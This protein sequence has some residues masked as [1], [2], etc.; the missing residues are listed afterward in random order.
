MK[1]QDLNRQ[2]L[3]DTADIVKA[4][5]P[6]NYGFLILAAPFNNQG[7]SRLVCTS[8]IRREDA[9]NMVKE[10]LLKAGAAEDWMRHIK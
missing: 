5:L 9:I 8:N 6:D 1:E 4:R 3:Q 10:W 7:D 2:F